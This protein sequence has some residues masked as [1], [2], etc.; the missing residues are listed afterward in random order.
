M[1]VTGKYENTHV[2]AFLVDVWTVC[3]FITITILDIIYS[4][5]V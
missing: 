2:K 5:F 1:S 3:V 4:V